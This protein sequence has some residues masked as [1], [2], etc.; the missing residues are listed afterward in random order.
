MCVHARVLDSTLFKETFSLA[1]ILLMVCVISGS[2][3]KEITVFWV[4]MQQVVAVPYQHFMTTYRS[5][6]Q[7]EII[8]KEIIAYRFLVCPNCTLVRHLT[9]VP[10]HVS[11]VMRY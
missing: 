4:I 6:R 8:Q 10:L 7:G 3:A 11:V 5:H 9:S 1:A 2:T